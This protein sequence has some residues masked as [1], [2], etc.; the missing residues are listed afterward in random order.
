MK[1]MTGIDL[2]SNNAVCGLVDMN[3]K[4]LLHDELLIKI[5][6]KYKITHFMLVQFSFVHRQDS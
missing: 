3:G 1:I 2:H 5:Y 6:Q 4:R